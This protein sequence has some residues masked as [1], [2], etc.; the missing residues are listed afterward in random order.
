MFHWSRHVF[1]RIK[2]LESVE[3]AI[4]L[5]SFVE[6]CTDIYSLKVCINKSVSVILKLVLEESMDSYLIPLTLKCSNSIQQPHQHLL[7]V[8]EI[9]NEF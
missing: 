3:K 4:V 7:Q 8:T 5:L 6:S 1:V 9:D 2:E